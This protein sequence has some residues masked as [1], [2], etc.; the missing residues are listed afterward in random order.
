MR[1]V[2]EL[3]EG[4]EIPIHRSLVQ[5]LYWMG[6]PRNLF[7]SE[8]LLGVLGESSSRPGQLSLS[9]LRCIICSVISD[10]RIRSS[11]WSFY[12]HGNIKIIIIAKGGGCFVF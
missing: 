5:P 12:G 6:V 2:E 8:I 11:I 4:Y 1:N 3:P 10:S 9:W 7:I